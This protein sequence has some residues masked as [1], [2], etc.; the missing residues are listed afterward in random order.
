MVIVEPKG[1]KTEELFKPN[2]RTIHTKF[3]IVFFRSR[4]I[5]CGITKLTLS[6]KLG[7]A[8]ILNRYSINN[9]TTKKMETPFLLK[10]KYASHVAVMKKNVAIT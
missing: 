2:Q 9:L 1:N 4:L 3:T 5:S 7:S 6:Q 8:S 10:P